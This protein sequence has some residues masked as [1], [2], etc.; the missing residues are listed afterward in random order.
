MRVSEIAMRAGVSI[1][2]VS[3]VLNNNPGVRR[4][5]AEQVQKILSEFPYDRHAVRRGPRSGPRRKAR[6]IGEM[7][8]NAVAIV[9]FG[10]AHEEWF[11]MPLFASIVS[12][13][14]RAAADRK[15]SVVIED[16]LDAN[17]I[18]DRIHGNSVDGAWASSRR[19]PSPIYLRPFRRGCRS[20]A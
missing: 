8:N 18:S 10:K 14:S 16:V 4:E 6:A 12:T 11:K 5:T 13:I 3:R 15:L 2:T 1:T 9:V 20:S 19:T 17:Q 7:R